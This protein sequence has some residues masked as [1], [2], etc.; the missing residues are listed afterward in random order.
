MSVPGIAG[1]VPVKTTVIYGVGLEDAGGTDC[2]GTQ[3][4][5]YGNKV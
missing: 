5:T 3:R 1:R 4:R 2:H